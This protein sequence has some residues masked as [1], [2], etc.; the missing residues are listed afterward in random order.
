[1][2]ATLTALVLIAFTLTVNVPINK[3][4]MTWDPEHPP[5]DWHRD[6][7]RWHTYQRLRAILVMSR[8]SP[9]LDLPA[10]CS[11]C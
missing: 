7:R 4:T 3:R 11:G 8:S 1:M 10:S 9:P 6:R 5:D 2:I